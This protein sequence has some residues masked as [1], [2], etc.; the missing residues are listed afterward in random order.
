MLAIVFVVAII[1]A[2]NQQRFIEVSAVLLFAVALLALALPVAAQE[3]TLTVLC[4]PQED[5]CVAM[6]QAF[7]A[8]TGI[9]TSYVRMSSGESLARLR[10][11]QDDPEFSVWWG[12]PA[13]AFIAATEED[14]S[15]ISSR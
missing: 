2:I 3:D 4:T 7:E 9:A 11:S 1:V 6:T 14:L 10:A 8:E 15:S 12:G 13:D 5:W